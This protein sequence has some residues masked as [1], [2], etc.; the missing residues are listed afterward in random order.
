MSIFLKLVLRV[1]FWDSLKVSI[2]FFQLVCKKK[3]ASAVRLTI[4]IQIPVTRLAPFEQFK[5]NY[6]PLQ[7]KGVYKR[8]VIAA[9]KVSTV[10]PLYY[11]HH[12]DHVKCPD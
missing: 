7:M 2:L 8:A 10:E 4:T 12:W 5:E 6:H 11:G 9:I 3:A 1:N